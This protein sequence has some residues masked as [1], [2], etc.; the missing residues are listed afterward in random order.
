MP[1]MTKRVNVKAPV[2][3]KT[4]TPP[5]Y[6]TC[7]DIIMTTGDIL[8]CLC[9]RATVEEILPNG[10]TVRL[11]MRNYYTDNGAGLD[12]KKALKEAKVTKEDKVEEKPTEIFVTGTNIIDTNDE[13][14][15][16]APS[17]KAQ[18][19]ETTTTNNLE[20]VNI[21]T[22]TAAENTSNTESETETVIAEDEPVAP[23]PKKKSSGKKKNSTTNK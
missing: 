17:E 11:N 19:V 16:E 15:P 20:E 10:S 12:A 9:K 18:V 22:K 8:K 7:N 3:I 6:G 13:K 21:A 5:I 1:S 23:T 14:V 2:A 4:I